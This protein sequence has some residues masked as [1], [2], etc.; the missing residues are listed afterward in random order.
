MMG[1]TTE[2]HNGTDYGYVILKPFPVLQCMY[3]SI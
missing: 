1:K 2:A 3:E